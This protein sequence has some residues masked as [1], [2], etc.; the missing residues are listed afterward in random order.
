[1]SP[2][3]YS[4]EDDRNISHVI[5][6]ALTNSGYDVVPFSEAKP[7][8]VAL[9]TKLPEL[10]LLDVMLPGMDGL[11]IVKS[12]RSKPSTAKI[13][14]MIISAKTT[15]ID[16]VVG[17]DLGADD[18]LAKPFGVLELISRVR[19]L[20]RRF[21]TKPAEEVLSAGGI[22]I[23]VREHTCFVANQAVIFTAKEFKLLT[24]LMQNNNRIVTRE[25]LLNQVWGFDFFGET[26]TL[27]VHIK[28]VRHK[29]ADAGLDPELIQTVRGIGY[30]FVA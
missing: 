29:L 10:F 9:E 4:V 1:M 7:M 16:K 12:L 20:L 25:E 6:I 30:K 5:Q 17:L 28:E 18:Y 11:E 15:E 2:L 24:V 21:E 13:P 8:F 27:D 3:I 22:D 23:D 14:V 19:A 26:R